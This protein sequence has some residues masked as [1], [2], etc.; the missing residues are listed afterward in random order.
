[1]GN[2]EILRWE[3]MAGPYARLY[4]YSRDSGRPRFFGDAG[5]KVLG[6]PKY[7]VVPPG[8]S[9]VASLVG[10]ESHTLGPGEYGGFFETWA[11][12]TNGGSADQTRIDLR[13]SVL[14]HNDINAG[15]AELPSAHTF[16]VVN[17]R[18]TFFKVN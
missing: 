3:G 18:D 6:L 15:S 8:G 12:P 11:V 1:M 2:G 4:I 16:S 17:G 13:E 7:V 5:M 14:R 9:A 10:D